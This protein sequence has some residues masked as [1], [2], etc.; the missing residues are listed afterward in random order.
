M[1]LVLVEFAGGERRHG[2]NHEQRGMLGGVDGLADFGNSVGDAGGSFVV[3]DHHG[4][5]GVIAVVGEAAL[6]V[7]GI[8]AVAPVAG[9][10]FHIESVTARDLLPKR[11]EL[12][13]FVHQDLVAGRKRIDDGGFP[14]TAAGR[15]EDDHLAGGAEDG[16]DA[17]ED[18]VAEAGEVGTA[19]VHDGGVHGALDAV[20]NVGGA[21]DL[22]EV[23]AG[24]IGHD[25][26]LTSDDFR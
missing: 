11:G 17:V 3:H 20:G 26:C 7:G 9:N 21:G 25:G 14:A 23:A 2:V 13:G 19:M 6:D 24:A 4:F 22:Q 1:P 16:L 10:K 12:A 5:E 8:H 15:R 18:F